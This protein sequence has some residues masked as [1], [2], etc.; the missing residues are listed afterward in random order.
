M[1]CAGLSSWASS[2]AVYNEL[3][4]RRPDVIQVCAVIML[5]QIFNRVAL[6]KAD[7][8][9]YKDVHLCADSERAILY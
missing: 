7:S 3:L 2:S 8:F 1:F 6:M 5:M 9:I 4:Q